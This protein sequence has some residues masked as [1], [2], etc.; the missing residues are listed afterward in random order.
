[1]VVVQSLGFLARS[2]RESLAANMNARVS[3]SGTAGTFSDMAK[4][5]KQ[6]DERLRREKRAVAALWP[7]ANQSASKRRL[8]TPLLFVHASELGGS[9]RCSEAD[10]TRSRLLFCEPCSRVAASSASSVVPLEIRE[11]GRSHIT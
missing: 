6:E 2:V 4:L 10:I 1:M 5:V 3:C 7:A 11:W 9:R 8:Q